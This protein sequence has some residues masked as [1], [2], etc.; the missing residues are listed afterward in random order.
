MFCIQQTK[1]L[2]HVVI[3][4]CAINSGSKTVLFC[5]FKPRSLKMQSNENSIH[6]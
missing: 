6:S 4:Y 3:I 1:K 5:I 2:T